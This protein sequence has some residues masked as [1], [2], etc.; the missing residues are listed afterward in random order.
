MVQ[1]RF[2]SL[3]LALMLSLVIALGVP[4]AVLG[5]DGKSSF[6]IPFI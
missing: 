2:A 1:L 6:F 3:L 4:S 5:N